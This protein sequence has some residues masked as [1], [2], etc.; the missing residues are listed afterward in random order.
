MVS[1]LQLEEEKSSICLA[2]SCFHENAASVCTSSRQYIL[3]IYYYYDYY[4]FFGGG[5]LQIETLFKLDLWYWIF[6]W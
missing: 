1:G 2:F 5:G 4:F 3:K 6:K